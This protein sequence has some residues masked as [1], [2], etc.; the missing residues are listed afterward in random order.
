MNAFSHRGILE[1]QPRLLSKQMPGEPATCPA[2]RTQG[3]S[4]LIIE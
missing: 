3:N 1:V 4:V 2:F